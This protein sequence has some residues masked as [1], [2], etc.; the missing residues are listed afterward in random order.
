[1][2]LYLPD[3]DHRILNSRE[4][5]G[6]LLWKHH[7]ARM[8]CSLYRRKGV[9]SDHMV[10]RFSFCNSDYSG[11]CPTAICSHMARYHTWMSYIIDWVVL[12]HQDS[13]AIYRYFPRSPI[14]LD[15]T[16][17]ITIVHDDR[18]DDTLA[19]DV[20]ISGEYDAIL[21]NLYISWSAPLSSSARRPCP[22]G[23]TSDGVYCISIVVWWS[24]SSGRKYNPSCI[25]IRCNNS[26]TST[27]AHGGGCRYDS[28]IPR[29]TTDRYFQ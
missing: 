17:T 28:V 9:T 6:I 2:C 12:P 22:P 18:D 5:T 25:C 8:T 21:G 4:S 14:E 1:M 3:A 20:R 29:H 23:D 26:C 10:I 19:S 15:T 27:E 7:K 11:F 16:S 13:L 24:E